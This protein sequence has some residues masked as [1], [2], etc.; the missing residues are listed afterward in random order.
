[1]VYFWTDMDNGSHRLT[2]P[3]GGILGLL[4]C[5]KW[6]VLT[7]DYDETGLLV[8]SQ[9]LDSPIRCPHY[10]L[11]EKWGKH[12]HSVGLLTDGDRKMRREAR[13]NAPECWLQ[14]PKL[15]FITKI[16]WQV[17]II[18][19]GRRC[20]LSQRE[21]GWLE[22]SC[23]LGRVNLGSCYCTAFSTHDRAAVVQPA[24]GWWKSLC[25]GDPVINQNHWKHCWVDTMVRREMIKFGFSVED[26]FSI[27][28][29]M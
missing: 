10:Q 8:A 7:S 5:S 1:M 14:G 4:E 16:R 11:A 19:L 3:A 20:L 23:F 9:S 24:S 15:V 21:V 22:A 17:E 25:K 28:T 18:L 26:I 13:Q 29:F 2:V 12:G 6:Q 27:L